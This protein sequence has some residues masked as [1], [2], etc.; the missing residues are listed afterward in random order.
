MIIRS[1]KNASYHGAFVR[2]FRF[3]MM[4]LSSW[5]LFSPQK[6][7]RI[8]HSKPSSLRRTQWV[9]HSIQQSQFQQPKRLTM[10]VRVHPIQGFWYV[11]GNRDVVSTAMKLYLGT[12]SS[13]QAAARPCVVH[14]GDCDGHFGDL[15]RRVLG[16]A[17]FELAEE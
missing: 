12:Y 5:A 8:M 4:V 16:R 15:K 14:T 13:S 1:E 2:S 7:V 9:F 3:R 11:R 10:R 6:H 17:R